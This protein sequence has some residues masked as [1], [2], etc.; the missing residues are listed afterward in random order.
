MDEKNREDAESS[1][2]DSKNLNHLDEN[3]AAELKSQKEYKDVQEKGEQESKDDFNRVY[4]DTD[5]TNVAN[6]MADKKNQYDGIEEDKIQQAKYESGYY[7]QTTAQY[8]F[9]SNRVTN[10][11]TFLLKYNPSEDKIQAIKFVLNL[12]H[13][14]NQLSKDERAQILKE[15]LGFD[16]EEVQTVQKFEDYRSAVVKQDISG[17]SA[18]QFIQDNKNYFSLVTRKTEVSEQNKNM[19]RDSLIN[20]LNNLQ[21]NWNLMVFSI[22]YNSISHLYNTQLFN[23]LQ[24]INTEE[25]NRQTIIISSNMLQIKHQDHIPNMQSDISDL[26]NDFNNY[27]SR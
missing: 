12:E 27:R 13:P 22:F 20:L 6:K 14:E 11:S 7:D 19:I 3:S 2:L 26:N 17:I 1:F 5:R 9:V 21:N 8:N 15:H 10:I 16:D 25:F 23:P 4:Y 18:D 24:G